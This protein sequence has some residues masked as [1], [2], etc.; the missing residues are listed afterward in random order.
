VPL[1]T[2]FEE[3]LVFWAAWK[4][5]L[6]VGARPINRENLSRWSVLKLVALF[7]CWHHYFGSRRLVWLNLNLELEVHDYLFL[8]FGTLIF[9]LNIST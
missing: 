8:V 2:A 5:H 3:T 4:F 1:M 7:H 6:A 9:H